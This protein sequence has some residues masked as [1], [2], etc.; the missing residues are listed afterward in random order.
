MRKCSK[1]NIVAVMDTLLKKNEIKG[2]LKN[3]GYK[4]CCFSPQHVEEPNTILPC[5]PSSPHP[6]PVSSIMSAHIIGIHEVSCD[7]DAPEAHYSL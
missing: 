6:S 7:H 2:T 5:P 3:K 1:S 4:L